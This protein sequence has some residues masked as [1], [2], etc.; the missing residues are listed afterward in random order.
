MASNNMAP[1]NMA[2]KQPKEHNT[3]RETASVIGMSIV[4]AVLIRTFIA[5]ARFIPSRSMVPTLAVGDRLMIEKL[6][7]R[8]GDPQR[9]DIIV[10]YPPDTAARCTP[11]NPPPTPIKDAYIKRVVGLPG[12]TIEVRDGSV[13]IDDSPLTEDYL[14]EPPKYNYGPVTVPA[15][16]YVVLGDNRNESCDSHIWGPVP[17]RQII[18]R[19]AIR[20]F[21]FDRLSLD[22]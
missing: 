11:Q 7:Y 22:F 19:T 21:P 14:S 4:F 16:T 13:Y 12:E 9:G 2:P 6:S 1:N 8:V 5:E 20:F 15:E 18:G 10:F 17:D 3:L